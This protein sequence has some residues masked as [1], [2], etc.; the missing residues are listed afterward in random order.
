MKKPGRGRMV[1]GVAAGTDMGEVDEHQVGED[2]TTKEKDRLTKLHHAHRE[3]IPRSLRKRGKYGAQFV[4]RIHQ[5]DY[6][7]ALHHQQVTSATIE[8]AKPEEVEDPKAKEAIQKAIEKRLRKFGKLTEVTNVGGS[9]L[10]ESSP[11]VG[12]R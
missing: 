12:P 3:N 8:H 6:W 7:Q 2:A 11:I 9:M 1:V 4:T 10:G 5:E